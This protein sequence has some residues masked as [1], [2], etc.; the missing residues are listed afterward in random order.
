MNPTPP[1]LAEWLLRRLLPEHD[2]ESI[3]GDL[4]ETLRADIA[5]DRSRSR[6]RSHEDIDA[7]SPPGSRLR[8]SQP[9]D[10]PG[11]WSVR[12]TTS[13]GCPDGSSG[14]IP[15]A[16]RSARTSVR[17]S[18]SRRS[19]RGAGTSPGRTFSADET[20]A[21]GSA[22]LVLLGDGWCT[23][24]FGR[25]PSIVGRTAGLNGVPHTV[26]GV[27]PR[28]FNAARRRSARPRRMPN[29]G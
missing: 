26:V 28:G 25:D 19:V 5:P 6:A 7:R 4:E 13:P 24:R 22:P 20:R 8:A 10:A 1:R 2:A 27:L 29:R 18:R 14:P 16:S 12:R 15:S 21:A 23:R 9:P 17:S 11:T 3:A